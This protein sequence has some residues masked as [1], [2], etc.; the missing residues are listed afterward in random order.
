M[1]FEQFYYLNEAKFSE[2]PRHVKEMDLPMFTL[3]VDQDIYIYEKDFRLYMEMADDLLKTAFSNARRR[4]S[5]LGFPSMHVNVILEDYS[6]I[7]QGN[8]NTLGYA[9]GN[10]R[11]STTRRHQL[12]RY[13]S[14]NHRLIYGILKNE[15]HWMP[16]LENTIVHEWAHLWMFNYGKRLSN[17]VQRL[18]TNIKDSQEDLLMQHM[19]GE[20]FEA[21]CDRFVNLI[22]IFGTRFIRSGE[23]NTEMLFD[24]FHQMENKYDIPK[25]QFTALRH[26]IREDLLT[27]IENT[28]FN[29]WNEYLRKMNLKQTL[30]KIYETS[31]MLSSLSGNRN[32]WDEK[33]A[34]MVKWSRGYGMKNM[35]ELWATGV[36]DFSKLPR[37]HQKRILSLMAETY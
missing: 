7:S 20:E 22:Q 2:S 9:M 34:D 8:T 32:A 10:P 27:F 28:D 23:L 30:K 16:V 35:D 4:I 24:V 29:G 5:K 37:E 15:T 11:K 25:F 21:D 26:Q 3:Y 1:T 17:A 18:Y 36:E 12:S 6:K 33:L 13:M 31:L 19:M 14:L